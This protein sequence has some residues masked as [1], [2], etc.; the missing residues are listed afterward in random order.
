MAGKIRVT[1]AG[2]PYRML[3]LSVLYLAVRDVRKSNKHTLGA[4]EFLYGNWCLHLAELID[5]ERDLA[6]L[7]RSL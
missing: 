2:N 3:V 1:K 5:V 4:L 7:V 6:D